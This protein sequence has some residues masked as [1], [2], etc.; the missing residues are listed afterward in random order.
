MKKR[1]GWSAAGMIIALGIPA[2]GL[3]LLEPD[4]VAIVYQFGEINRQLQSG[5]HF[6]LPRP[7]ESHTT[8]A[9]TE[10][11]TLPIDS[12]HLLTSD[13]SLID[14]TL[15]VQ[16][17]ISDPVAFILGSIDPTNTVAQVVRGASAQAAAT[18][19]IDTMIDNRGVLQDRIRTLS[20]ADLDMLET[21]IRVETIDVQ[22]L[23]PP[24]PVLD[25]FNDVS[26]A[27]SDRE[28]T[29]LAAHS[30]A[31]QRGPESRGQASEIINEAESWR[32]EYLSEVE[33]S[34]SRFVQLQ[35]QHDK[36]SYLWKHIY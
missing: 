10:V 4:E 34:I 5:L 20:Q 13:A 3:I 26:S 31:R 14:L 9:H 25:A 2:E 11:R 17:T 15:S 23:S 24:P 30:Y 35:S 6:R 29:I 22:D 36:N 1:I 21:G 28:T 12:Q 16:Y 7:I 27:K 8:V 33:Q 32:A 19:D 18:T